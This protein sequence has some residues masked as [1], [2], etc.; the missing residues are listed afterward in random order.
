MGSNTASTW[1]MPKYTDAEHV[2]CSKGQHK[3]TLHRVV[4]GTINYF[5]DIEHWY[6]AC[7]RYFQMKFNGH[8]LRPVMGE[9]AAHLKWIEGAEHMNRVWEKVNGRN[10]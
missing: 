6:C 2:L 9:F 4:F 5:T 8:F 10:S 1:E 3:E 7:G